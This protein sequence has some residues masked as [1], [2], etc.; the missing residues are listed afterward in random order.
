MWCFPVPFT[1][2]S[3]LF[4]KCGYFWKTLR[5]LQCF[6]RDNFII[7]AIKWNLF[8]YKQMQQYT[9]YKSIYLHIIHIYDWLTRTFG[10]KPLTKKSGI[11]HRCQYKAKYWSAGVR[12]KKPKKPPQKS[13]LFFIQ[14]FLF[15]D[16][17][18][19]EQKTSSKLFSKMNGFPRFKSL[20]LN[21]EE[22]Y[23]RI[24]KKSENFYGGSFFDVKARKN[25]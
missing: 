15:D 19:Y 22:K 4:Y 11:L 1:T 13:S 18:L 23:F 24:F 14:K 20:F 3:R 6:E 8:K 9:R 25:F 2:H 7:F 12:T 16:W 5:I 10:K 21:G 17:F